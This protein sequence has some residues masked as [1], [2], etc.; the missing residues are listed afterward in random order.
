MPTLTRPFPPG[1][2]F[3]FCHLLFPHS[4]FIFF[5]P[6]IFGLLPTP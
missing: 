3:G 4:L 6:L 1:P 2:P 5:L